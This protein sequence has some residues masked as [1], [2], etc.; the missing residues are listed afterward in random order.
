MNR[1]AILADPGFGQLKQLIIDRTGMAYYADKD[2]D[3]AER[4][5][6]RLTAR[7][8]G[9]CASYG[10]ALQSARGGAAEMDALVEEITIGETYFFRQTAQFDALR[11]VVMPALVERRGAARRLRIWS[12]GCATGAEAYSVALLLLGELAGRVAG[13]DVGI[14]ATDINRRFLARAREARFD[15]WAFREGPDDIQERYFQ[16]DGKQW[17]LLP[18]YRNRVVFDYHNL[19]SDPFPRPPGG[20]AGFDL[21]LCRNVMIYFGAELV[22]ATVDRLYESLA[23]DGWLL[24]GHAEPNAGVFHAFEPVTHAGETLYR[25]G[26]AGAPSAPAADVRPPEIPRPVPPAPPVAPSTRRSP[27]LRGRL[28]RKREPDAGPPA[29][30]AEVRD[31]AD[32]GQWQAALSSCEELLRTDALN[33]LAHFTM[34]LILEHGGALKATESALRRALY[35]DSGFILAHYHLGVVTHRN[36]DRQLARRAFENALDLL[37]AKPEADLVEHGDGITAAELMDLTRMHLE[38]LKGI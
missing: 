3:L 9:A 26:A 17:V 25:K 2:E 34:A 18:E 21:I 28:A 16:R 22:R 24:V 37:R 1:A 30:L 27:G 15:R 32:R 35:L 13:W 12:A 33:P 4:I 19:V 31:L 20:G 14:L 6:R 5:G 10:A 29:T 23:T 11:R 36:R 38:T 8:G 7:G